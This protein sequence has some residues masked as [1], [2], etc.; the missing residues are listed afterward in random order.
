MTEENGIQHILFTDD[1]STAFDHDHRIPAAGNHDIYVA[2]CQFFRRRIAQESSIHPA[3]FD[4]GNGAEKRDVRNL[5]RRRCT[6]HSEDAWIVV[7]VGRDHRSHYLGVIKEIL[8]EK[9]PDRPVYQTACQGFAF[10]R[11]AFPFEES[12]G[13]LAACVS[14]F[15]IID[16]ERKKILPFLGGF[17]SHSSNQHH[18]IAASDDYCSTCL[19]RH[20]TCF[21]GYDFP[22]T[23]CLNSFFH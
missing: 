6:D 3:N 16:G 12:T 21:D 19:L 11:A 13:Y 22:V 20:P 2:F 8:R 5:E 10:G 7:P 17:C 15:L 14:L 18:G 1:V 23:F 4:T 9:G